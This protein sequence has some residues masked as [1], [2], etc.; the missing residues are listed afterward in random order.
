MPL[1]RSRPGR[2]DERPPRAVEGHRL[3]RPQRQR[4]G[5][6]ARGQRREERLPLPEP[7]LVDI[8]L[9][10]PEVEGCVD[11]AGAHTGWEDRASPHLIRARRSA[12]GRREPAAGPSPSRAPGPVERA[13]AGVASLGPARRAR[14][15][16]RDRVDGGSLEHH[17]HLRRVN[18]GRRAKRFAATAATSGA[19][20]DVPSGCASLGGAHGV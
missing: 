20:N 1:A 10:V 4:R 6:A 11:R 17:R 3:R 18:V 2:G 19:E 9:V 8:L 12:R 14:T 5:R 7:D 13:P 16:L 15:P